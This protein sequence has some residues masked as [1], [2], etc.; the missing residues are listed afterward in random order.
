MI[1]TFTSDFRQFFLF[2]VKFHLDIFSTHSITK[3]LLTN[4]GLYTMMLSICQPFVC[5]KHVY[6]K[7]SFLKKQFRAMV[8]VDH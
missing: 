8:S 1:I 2:N 3:P 6:K 7:C 4:V 5:L